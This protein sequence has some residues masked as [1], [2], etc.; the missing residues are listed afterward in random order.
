LDHCPF[1]DDGSIA[2]CVSS[3]QVNATIAQLEDV[4]VSELVRSLLAKRGV[5]N[6]ANISAFLSPDYDAHTHAP[7]LLRRCGCG[8]CA[9]FICDGISGTALLAD[10]FAK[11]NDAD[12]EFV[13]CDLLKI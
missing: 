8:I 4:I 2:H 13:R 6:D 12:V 3:V 11:I 7:D 9:D 5:V 1:N 10:F